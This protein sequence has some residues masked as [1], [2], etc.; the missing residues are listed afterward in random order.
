MET[1][2][3]SNDAE[4]LKTLKKNQWKRKITEHFEAMFVKYSVHGLIKYK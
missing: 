1:I 2:K 3:I 4:N